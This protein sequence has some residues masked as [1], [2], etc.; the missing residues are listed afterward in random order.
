MKQQDIELCIFDARNFQKHGMYDEAITVLLPIIDL[1]QKS[2]FQVEA[3]KLLSFNYRKLDDVNMAMYYIQ[4]ALKLVIS[5]KGKEKGVNTEYAVCLMNKGVI[6]ESRG[7]ITNALSDYSETLGI[8]QGLFDIGE[9]DNGILINALLTIGTA[10]Y[11]KNDY[12]SAKKYLMD[13]LVYF[14]D[15]CK[16]DRRYLAI[17]N[18]LTEIESYS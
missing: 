2:L 18:T 8:F 6:N 3:L 14:G 17:K 10:C 16:T 4:R 12:L 9:V 7:K 1:P 5:L 13:A 15:D 11:N